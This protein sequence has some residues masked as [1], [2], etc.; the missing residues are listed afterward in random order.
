MVW[1]FN[2]RSLADKAQLDKL[3][4]FKIWD[5]LK[6]RAYDAPSS[7]DRKMYLTLMNDPQNTGLDLSNYFYLFASRL[8]D[9]SITGMVFCM[10]DDR[11]WESF[12]KMNPECQMEQGNGFRYFRAGSLLA[13][14]DSKK[15]VLLGLREEEEEQDAAILG[16]IM[17]TTQS[18][19]FAATSYYESFDDKD[20]DMWGILSVD[21]LTKTMQRL[22]GFKLA[23]YTADAGADTPAAGMFVTFSFNFK[24]NQLQLQMNMKSEQKNAFSVGSVYADKGLSKKHQTCMTNAGSLGMIGMSVDMDLFIKQMSA[25]PSAH[26][27]LE[28]MLQ[29]FG[30]SSKELQKMLTGEISMTLTD[31]KKMSVTRRHMEYNEDTENYE[32]Q[33]DQ[34]ETLMP[35][36]VATL[37]IED[38]NTLHQLIEKAGLLE[39]QGLYRIH[40]PVLELFLVED[41]AGITLTD[42][43][44]T[45]RELAS[46]KHFTKTLSEEVGK[47]VEN[48]S[49]VF[50]LDLDLKDYPSS[51]TDQL[52]SKMDEEGWQKLNNIM[53]I[54]R[55]VRAYGKKNLS[56][57]EV[58]L[59]DGGDNSLY[60]ILK[61]LDQNL[62]VSPVEQQDNQ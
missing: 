39:D 17:K 51:F 40:T 41:D 59:T 27:Q 30:I 43:E 42:E 1:G 5:M 22:N 44:S 16:K 28:E 56:T 32:I 4:K 60:R 61:V 19:S 33:E 20:S 25:N 18:G 14:W 6:T 52:K 31:W 48:N 38:R 2:P 57:L 36:F 62:G 54:F 49:G 50:Y 29:Q 55:D 7:G 47:L 21:Q 8:G 37:G 13:G 53:S 45:A 58:N 11:K 23:S 10:D 3:K 12:I 24:K 35:V 15:A 9:K 46:K 26:L 34:D